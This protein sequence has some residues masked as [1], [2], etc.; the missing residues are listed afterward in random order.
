M[1]TRPVIIFIPGYTLLS[2]VFENYSA[3]LFK[4]GYYVVN[5]ENYEG[6]HMSQLHTSIDQQID[7]LNGQDYVLIGQSIGFK[8]AYSYKTQDP[9]CIAI[10]GLN[11]YWQ[12]PKKMF[13]GKAIH[14]VFASILKRGLLNFFTKPIINRL[15]S[16]KRLLWFRSLINNPTYNS[17]R[18]FRSVIELCALENPFDTIK[19]PSFLLYT[20]QTVN[21]RVTPTHVLFGK[22]DLLLKKSFHNSKYFETSNFP[23]STIFHELNGGHEGFL[24]FEL[25]WIKYLAA[26]LTEIH[27]GESKS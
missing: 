17:R 5:I 8:I 21:S 24:E 1:N 11:P 18:L 3:S 20:N 7:K 12:D 10:I 16:P 9:K 4:L 14:R 19:N 2:S 15:I 23:K 13:F 25:E 22:D 6:T 26:L 27:Y